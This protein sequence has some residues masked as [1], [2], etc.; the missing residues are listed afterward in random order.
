MVRL[1]AKEATAAIGTVL[2]ETKGQPRGPAISP[3]PWR[4]VRLRGMFKERG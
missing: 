2:A 1:F 3:R 4:T